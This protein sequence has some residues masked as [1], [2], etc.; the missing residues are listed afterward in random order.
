VNLDYL[1]QRAQADVDPSATLEVLRQDDFLC[2]LIDH[3]SKHPGFDVG[4]IGDGLWSEVTPEKSTRILGRLHYSLERWLGAVDGERFFRQCNRRHDGGSPQTAMVPI[5]GGEF[6]MGSPKSEAGR[7][8]DEVQ[9]RV[10]LSPFLLSATAVTNA[11]YERFDPTHEREIFEGKVSHR[12]AARHPVVN[13][14]WWEARLYC[15]WAGGRLPTEA[16]WEYACRAGT[17]TPFS[18]GENITPKQV[19]YDGNWPYAGGA[20]GEYR[21]R[22][23]PVGSLPASP[24]GLCEMH[25]NVWEWCGDWYGEYAAEEQRDPVG[26]ASGSNRVIRGG[27]WDNQA[28]DCRSAYRS[29]GSP[30]L[31]GN[32]F[33]GFRLAVSSHPAR[34]NLPR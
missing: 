31:P 4:Q 30:S 18:L 8:H 3:W 32:R 26:P 9:H 33:L 25:G 24:W 21:K 23:V 11:E 20:M 2:G 5:P 15:A 27:C 22:P 6:L 16:E 13:V 34:P 17:K 19:N 1:P 29:G 14:S 12:K 10:H 28:Q 7:S